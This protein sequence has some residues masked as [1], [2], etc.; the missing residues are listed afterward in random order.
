M[1]GSCTISEVTDVESLRGLPV[2]LGPERE[3]TLV[4][5]LPQVLDGARLQGPMG[6]RFVSTGA[7]ADKFFLYSSISEQ[8]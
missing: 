7:V 4:E 3:D 2:G 5:V 1:K 8:G 6:T